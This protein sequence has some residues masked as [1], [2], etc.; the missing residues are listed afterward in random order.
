MPVTVTYKKSAC[1][2]IILR[3][4]NFISQCDVMCVRVRSEKLWCAV[5]A[6][7]VIVF[8]SRDT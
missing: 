6:T 4:D 8:I 7:A 1:G 3:G 2:L 5:T